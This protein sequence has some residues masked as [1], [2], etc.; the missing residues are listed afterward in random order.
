[1]KSHITQTFQKGYTMKYLYEQIELNN[2]VFYQAKVPGLLHRG[3]SL[4][5]MRS[6]GIGS[7]LLFLRL[8]VRM[9]KHSLLT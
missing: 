3:R 5:S 9:V 2:N 1:M 6:A 4:M 8:K 7:W